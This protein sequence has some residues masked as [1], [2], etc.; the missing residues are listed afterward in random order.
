MNLSHA[1]AI[2]LY[3]LNNCKSK[4]KNQINFNQEIYNLATPKEINDFLD[5]TKEFLLKIGFLYQH[6]ALSRIYK[7]K[8]L[9]HRAE[10][11]SEEV[12]LV[13][14]ILRQTKWFI[15]KKDV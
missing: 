3:E 14:G 9:L 15:N 4:N 10:V 12:S 6:T 13:R 5:D 11:R 8:A 1:V 7:I 2:V